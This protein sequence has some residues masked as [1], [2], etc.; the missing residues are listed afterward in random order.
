M[1]GISRSLY[2][3]AVVLVAV[4]DHAIAP[5]L[6]YSSQEFPHERDIQITVQR[7]GSFSC[8]NG[9]CYSVHFILAKSFLMRGISR[10]LNREAV[11]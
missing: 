11:V 4:A 2:R 7:G 8:S 3:E 1:R 10:L 5:T 9:S 6:Y